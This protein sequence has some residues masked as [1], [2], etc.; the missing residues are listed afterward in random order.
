MEEVKILIIEDED[1]QIQVYKDTID[2][3]NKKND[4][5]IIPEICKNF[6]EGK[7]ALLS[8]FYDA[9]IIDLKLSS[10]EELEGKKLLES[11]YQKL[12]IPIVVYSGSIGQVDDIEQTPLLLKRLRTEKL[13]DI[14]SEIIKIYNTGITRYLRPSG[15][16][17]QKLTHIFWNNLVKDLENWVEHNNPKTLL[18][19]IFTHFQE[20]MNIDTDGDFEI[21]HP[22]EV[23]ISPPIKS[24]IHTGDLLKI[25]DVF[26]IVMNPACDIVLHHGRDEKGNIVSFRKA[27]HLIVAKALQF[28]Y[29][30]LCKNKKGGLDKSKIKNFI[31]NKLFRYHYLPPLNGNNGFLIDF[32]Q[33][34]SFSFESEWD[35]VA[36]ITSP[37]IKDIISR[38][39]LYYARQGQPVYNQD[40][41]VEKFYNSGNKSNKGVK[42]F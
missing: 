34:S 15:L 6:E 35:N 21:Y 25:N 14:L 7:N 41:L 1:S 10:S 17:D 42:L 31:T 8:P 20:H 5:K 4:L 2:S 23:Y 28:D 18:R 37:F 32:Q 22:A 11:V 38:F 26:Y 19:Y 39:S 36:T 12:R 33:L 27:D 9:A 24:N 16:L 40:E 13:A 3:F 30:S 29:K